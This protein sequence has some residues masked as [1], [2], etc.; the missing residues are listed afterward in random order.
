MTALQ[1]RKPLVML[2][3][4]VC[5]QGRVVSNGEYYCV[6]CLK[7]GVWVNLYPAALP[8]WRG[9]DIEI[10]EFPPK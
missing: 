8:L 3:Y 2:P 10:G 4:V 6:Y 1:I 5:E 7:N 9:L